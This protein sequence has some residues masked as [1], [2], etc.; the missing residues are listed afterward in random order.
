MAATRSAPL[1]IAGTAIFGAGFGGLQN[2]GLTVIYAGADPAAYG[3][4]A[5]LWNAAYDGGMAAGAFA[6]GLLVPL[7]GFPPAFLV[8]AALMALALLATRPSIRPLHTLESS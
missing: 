3:A 2:A 6:V 8:T 1:V 5:A 4:V 7:T